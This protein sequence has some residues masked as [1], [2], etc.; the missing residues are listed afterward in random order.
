MYTNRS[1]DWIR[2]AVGCIRYPPDRN[3]VEKELYDHI[4]CRY[5]ENLALGMNEKEADEAAVKA[6]GD[7]FEVGRELAKI[8]K[9]FW[10]FFLVFLRIFA[11]ATL[12]VSAL[13]VWKNPPNHTNWFSHIPYGSVRVEQQGSVRCGD[14]RFCADWA[15]QAA[16]GY[17]YF[18]LTYLT[19]NPL[20]HEPDLWHGTCTLTDSAGNVSHCIWSGGNSFACWGNIFF[21]AEA[22]GFTSGLLEFCYDNG[23]A[24]F[25]LPLTMT[26]DFR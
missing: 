4:M 23:Y 12:I 8:H 5:A 9:P 21:C 3:D 25:K 10:G 22:Q 1:M 6:M 14:Y 2:R 19:A 7:P 17:I 16:N 24:S 18:E 26:G 13:L 15:A 20:L 11:A